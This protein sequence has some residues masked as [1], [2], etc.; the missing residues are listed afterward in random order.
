M[1]CVNNSRNRLT[2]SFAKFF[3]IFLLDFVNFF[4]HFLRHNAYLGYY[5]ENAASTLPTDQCQEGW[6]CTGCAWS[7]TPGIATDLPYQGT[8]YALSEFS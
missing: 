5:C 6:Y 7:S 1:T 8:F 2:A 4:D 3:P